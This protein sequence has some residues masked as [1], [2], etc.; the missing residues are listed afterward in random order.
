MKSTTKVI[1]SFYSPIEHLS[2]SY[3]LVTESEERLVFSEM[4]NILDCL[5]KLSIIVRKVEE[6]KDRLSSVVK[7]LENSRSYFRK[8]SCV[9]NNILF[10]LL[11]L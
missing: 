6:K 1:I 8:T 3:L 7:S 9:I 2:V 10:Q 11:G 5:Q 4:L